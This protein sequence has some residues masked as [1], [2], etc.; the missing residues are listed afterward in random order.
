MQ[1][2]A[3]LTR[4]RFWLSGAAI[5]AV[6]AVLALQPGRSPHFFSLP[7]Y[8]F[9]EYWAAG[10]LI[11]NGENPYDPIR[12]GYLEHEAGRDDQPL[13]MWNPPWVLPA[14]LPFGL[15]PAQ[16]GRLLWLV[17]SFGIVLASADVAWHEFGGPTEK[18][19]LAWL[20]A[21]SFVPTFLT[22][23]LGQI[24]AALLAGAVLFLRFERR[25][26]DLRAGAATILLAAKPHLF[27]PF[28]VALALWA[29]DQRRW[30]VL[31][32]GILTGLAA[33]LVAIM[34]DPAVLSQ[35][36]ETLIQSPPV[37]YR[38]PTAGMV[39]R[40]LCG[41]EGSFGLQF[42]A[43]IPGFLWLVFEWLRHGRT[44]EWRE[45]LPALLF[46]SL[47]TAPYGAWPFDLI[48]L[49]VPLLR[50]ASAAAS[51]IALAPGALALY[52]IANGAAVICVLGRVDF[53]WW[54]WLTPA[55][56]LAYVASFA[57][58]QRAADI[59]PLEQKNSPLLLNAT[60][61]GGALISPRPGTP[62]RGVGGEGFRALGRAPHP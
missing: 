14:V 1:P 56:L 6:V 62:G 15:L 21:F 40:L 48:V 35:Y 27:I 61:T 47:L 53:F 8:D 44:R 33:T 13:L 43:L 59:S 7:L 16:V 3:N 45:R 19:G 25:G 36:R 54:L 39:L 20:L 42:V 4:S 10:R 30:R 18:R 51:G 41:D 37:Q 9:V 32:G 58:P 38:S 52:L 49:L 34:F 50:V 12:V 31:L 11:A 28:W 2:S 26:Q 55:L 22:L 5:A 60:G 57:A 17:L 23:Y 24:A 46:A 29:V